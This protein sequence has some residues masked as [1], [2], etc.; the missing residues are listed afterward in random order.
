MKM[1]QVTHWRHYLKRKASY[2]VM[3]VFSQFRN[4]QGKFQTVHS[5]TRGNMFL[6][7]FQVVLF[8]ISCRDVTSRLR[9]QGSECYADTHLMRP[10]ERM[11]AR[12]T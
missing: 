8:L 1:E 11:F 9:H 6:L 3:N 7:C 2:E 4:Y 5:I 10:S 12:H